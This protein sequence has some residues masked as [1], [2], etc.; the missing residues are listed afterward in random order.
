MNF[1]RYL[2]LVFTIFT[3]AC[4]RPIAE[5]TYDGE[6]QAPATIQ[7]ENLSEKAVQYEWDFGD[8]NKTTTDN[9]AHRYLSSG[10]FQV[11]LT[12]KNEK[13]ARTIEK[14]ILIKAPNECLVQMET[15]YGPML[16]KLFDD[17]PKHQENFVK[18][19][20]QG[21]FDSL[22]FH[23]VIRG[24]MIQG[25]DPESKN[26][27]SNKRLGTGGPGYT[28]P[29]EFVDT[30]LHQKGALAAARQ[31]DMVNPQKKSS[32]SQFYIVQGSPINE[33]LLKRIEAQKGIRYTDQQ[34]EF[35][36][37]IGG[38]PQLDMEYTVFGQ[39]IEGIGIIDSIA[40]ERTD[41]SDRP[42]QDI[43]MKVKV[44]K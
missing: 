29:A 41:G 3:L 5:F 8:G 4:S 17:T 2:I 39:V 16:I 15:P 22:L 44:I 20:D 28:I 25:G 34:K 9:P 10:N 7:F 11:K 14:R 1:Q 40:R 33:N 24:F 23:R 12:A 38:T 18:L 19:A 43:W 32:G 37:T 36:Q 26:A 27:P 30:L 42:R 21:Y 35:Y 13:K 31:G 6:M